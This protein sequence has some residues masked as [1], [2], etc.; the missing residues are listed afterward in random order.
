MNLAEAVARASG[1]PGVF[2]F[3]IDADHGAIGGQQVRN[4]RPDA[5]AGARRRHGEQMRRAVIA[6]QFSG[7]RITA[8]EQARLAL[9]QGQDFLVRGETGGAVGV[10]LAIAEMLDE[11]RGRHAEEQR[12]KHDNADGIADRVQPGVRHPDLRDR[13]FDAEE[14]HQGDRDQDANRLR[15]PDTESQ[16]AEDEMRE[17]PDGITRGGAHHV[18]KRS[19]SDPHQECVAE[20][21]S[22]PATPD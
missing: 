1:D 18:S 11:R 13:V 12:E 3:G 14:Q 22:A 15:Q 8:D 6:Q 17:G 10:A 2:A 16:R 4:D 7:F 19:P 9:S 5:L 21:D 20:D